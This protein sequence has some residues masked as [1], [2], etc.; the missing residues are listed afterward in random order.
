[1]R[2][3]ERAAPLK[4]ID[5]ELVKLVLEKLRLSGFEV[6]VEQDSITISKGGHT[7]TMTLREFLD[8]TRPIR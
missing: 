6:V 8:P 3:H 4:A 7:R 5:P 2:D 1:M